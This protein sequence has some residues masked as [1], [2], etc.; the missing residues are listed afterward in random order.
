MVTIAAIR[1]LSEPNPDCD[2]DL[3]LCD[4]PVREFPCF[5]Y[6]MMEVKRAGKVIAGNLI[7][8]DETEAEIREAFKIANNFR[9][10]HAFPMR[11]VRAHLIWY[12]R[13]HDWRSPASIF[14]RRATATHALVAAWAPLAQASWNSTAP[15]ASVRV[16]TSFS[17]VVG[18]LSAI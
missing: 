12:M 8:T 16:T 14:A 15:W 4:L 2:S 18:C 11:S 5:E 3:A 9:S 17:V 1:P 6:S 13:A 7:W 10:A